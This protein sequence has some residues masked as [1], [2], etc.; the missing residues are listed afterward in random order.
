MEWVIIVALMTATLA[1]VRTY[2]K[3]GIQ[4]KT[5]TFADYAFWQKWDSSLQDQDKLNALKANLGDTASKS[6]S[7]S[8]QGQTV[9]QVE[10]KRPEK[11]PTFYT[12]VVTPEATTEKTASAST[13]EGAEPLLKTVDINPVT[14]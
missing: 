6:K 12:H 8:S 7:I 1:Y 9:T 5:M 4:V 2:L 3:R 11:K 13:E 10:Q 14:N